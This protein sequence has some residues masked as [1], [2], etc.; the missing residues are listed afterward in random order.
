MKVDHLLQPAFV[1]SYDLWSNPGRTPRELKST[2]RKLL[3]A[4]LFQLAL[5]QKGQTSRGRKFSLSIVVPQAMR[6]VCYNFRFDVQEWPICIRFLPFLMCPLWTI[7]WGCNLTLN[8]LYP[9]VYLAIMAFAHGFQEELSVVMLVSWST[10]GIGCVFLSPYPP[11]LEFILFMSLL[12]LYAS[13]KFV[14]YH[15]F[16]S[17]YRS[18]KALHV[19]VDST[20]SLNV[21]ADAIFTP[22]AHRSI[23]IRIIQFSTPYD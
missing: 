23:I 7:L 14:Y 13:S 4:N 8:L 19:Y 3:V 12:S 21:A 11:Q 16:N 18:Y 17:Y 1:I 2:H 15:S 9:R 10:I 20:V 22:Q 5:C 6:W